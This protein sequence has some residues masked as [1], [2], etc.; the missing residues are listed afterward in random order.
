METDL[1]RGLRPPPEVSCM[2]RALLKPPQGEGRRGGSE[3]L[4]GFSAP[5]GPA[6]ASTKLR[7]NP[8]GLGGILD[9]S[10]RHSSL[11]FQ[12]HWPY[13]AKPQRAGRG[14]AGLP[15]LCLAKANARGP[16]PLLSKRACFI[17]PDTA[18]C[19]TLNTAERATGGSHLSRAQSVRKFGLRFTGEKDDTHHRVPAPGTGNDCEGVEAGT[20][21]GKTPRDGVRL[22]SRAKRREGAPERRGSG[23]RGVAQWQKQNVAIVQE[24]AGDGDGHQKPPHPSPA[25]IPDKEPL[26]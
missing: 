18:L 19:P 2:D 4:A 7:S 11:P 14:P 17:A 21:G 16:R 8:T 24:T 1:D 23:G 15:T 6:A 26:L 22:L 9:L 20:A 25:P 10:G 13:T 3:R 12:S 5:G